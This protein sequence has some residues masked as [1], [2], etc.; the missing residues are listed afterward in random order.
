MHALPNKLIRQRKNRI[1]A[2]PNVTSITTRGC[3][4]ITL[5]HA[6][7][8]LL[9]DPAQSC[10]QHW[11][12]M[13]PSFNKRGPRAAAGEEFSAHAADVDCSMQLAFLLV[14]AF[15]DGDIQSNASA[16]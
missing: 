12:T 9:T 13:R 3:S 7:G 4:V 16:A 5:W 8:R 2:A 1:K 10:S 11:K 6:I 15:S 14:T